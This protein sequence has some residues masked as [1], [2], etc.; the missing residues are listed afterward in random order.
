MREFRRK[1]GAYFCKLKGR[2]SVITQQ[3]ENWAELCCTVVWKA[4]LI[5]DKTGYLA[6]EISKPTVEG[7][8]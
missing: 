2:K 5:S 1:L 8:A 3:Q 4:E 6:G 7:V